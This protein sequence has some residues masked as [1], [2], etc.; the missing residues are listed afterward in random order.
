MMV[1]PSKGVTDK[2]FKPLCGA[3]SR[4]IV[5]L[6]DK[7]KVRENSSGVIQRAERK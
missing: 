4:K 5:V 2:S 7:E 3:A 1:G 6:S